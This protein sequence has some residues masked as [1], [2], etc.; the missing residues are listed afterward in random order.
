MSTAAVGKPAPTAKHYLAWLRSFRF[1]LVMIILLLVLLIVYH[2]ASDRWTPMTSSA[3]AQAYVVQVAPRIEGQVIRVHVKEN[4][5]VRQGDLLFEIDPRP[6]EHRTAKLKARLAAVIKQ[7]AQMES[8]LAALQADDVRMDAEMKYADAVHEIDRAAYVRDA[9]SEEEMLASIR[10]MTTAKAEKNRSRELIRKAEQGLA[11]RIGSEHA[12]IAEARAELAEADLNLLFTR[13]VAPS[14]GLITDVQ[15]RVGSHVKPGDAV[16]SCIDTRQWFVVADFRENCLEHVEADQNAQISFD[17]YPGRL[18]KARVFSVGRGVGQG[19]GI[20][21]GKLP[22]V[23]SSSP[24]IRLG[25][26]FQVRLVLD[27]ETA[28]P[29][30]VGMRATVSVYCKDEGFLPGVTRAVHRFLT[31]VDYLL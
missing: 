6:F 23:Q 12:L 22:K 14:D 15:L 27:D 8:D 10:S 2:V 18:Y 29:M 7:V 4:D 19:Q 16:L 13:V 1:W 5:T 25:Q 26:R 17:N 24:W 30:R 31:W 11:A 3:Y 28:P 9:I 21:T 20:P